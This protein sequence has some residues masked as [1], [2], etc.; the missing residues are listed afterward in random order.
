MNKCVHTSWI[1]L[2][3][4]LD[5]LCSMHEKAQ[6]ALTIEAQWDIYRFLT[7]L[8]T[9]IWDQ[10][11]ITNLPPLKLSLMQV[12]KVLGPDGNFR[13]MLSLSPWGISP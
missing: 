10:V 4:L 9:F 11:F 1:F 6:V 13:C 2:N 5:I 8:P 12:S 3:R 7:F